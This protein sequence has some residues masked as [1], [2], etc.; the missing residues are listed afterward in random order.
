[1]L[2]IYYSFSVFFL[3]IVSCSTSDHQDILIAKG[4]R[5]YGGTASYHASE[6]SDH[7]FPMSVISM[8]DQRV[9]APIFET[10]LSY[11]EDAQKLVSNF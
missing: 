6:K 8:Y 2:K 5:I 7:I 4:G 1:M 3:L 11:D 9:T 10:L